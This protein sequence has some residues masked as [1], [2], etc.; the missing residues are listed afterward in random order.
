MDAPRFSIK[1]RLYEGQNSIIFRGV[2]ADGQTRVVIKV[3]K[4]EYP[5][6]RAL[7]QLRREYAT[8]REL[9]IPGVIRVF[10]LESY[11]NG[12]ALVM[13]DDGGVPLSEIIRGEA[14]Q[15]R[16]ALELAI[17]LSDTLARLHER[18]IIHKDIKPHN[19]L[20]N[21]ATGAVKLIDF[22][23]ATNLAHA[24]APVASP[25][26]IEGT[27]MYM[28]PEQ[29]GRVNRVVDQR[30][31]LYSLGVTLYEMLTGSV[32]FTAQD[33]MELVHSHIA[34]TP[35]PPWV[36]TPT[37]PRVLSDIVMKLLA[38]GP[39]DRYQHAHGLSADLARCL[40]E[41]DADGSVRP[42]ELG[43]R[44]RADV[45]RIPQKLYG[46]E[47][48]V[49]A[50]TE[51]YARVQDGR[52]ELLLVSGGAGVGKSMLAQEAHKLIA[53]SGGRVVS[54]K[55]DLVQ[56]EV[57]FS[58]LASALTDLV[59]QMLTESSRTLA[60]W[61]ARIA[62]AL[63]GCGQLVVDLVPE[64]SRVIGPQPPL[65]PLRPAESQ[66]RFGLVMQNFVRALCPRT[67][68]LI[69]LL[70]DL[71]WADA[72]TLSLLRLLLTDPDGGHLLIVGAYRDAEVDGGHPLRAA[73]SQLR[74]DGAAI[75]ELTL[76]P[77]D[78]PS[79]RALLADTLTHE[80]PGAPVQGEEAARLDALASLVF[81]KTHGNPFFL[82][83]FLTA[84]HRGGQLRFDHA[85]G[86]WT[87]DPA[88]I[89]AAPIT[90]NVAEL[91]STRLREFPEDTQQLLAIAACV[92]HEFD[93]VTLARISQRG[94]ARVAEELWP[95]LEA[96]LVVPLD[97]NFRLLAADDDGAPEVGELAVACRFLHDRV[98]QAALSL[99]TPEALHEVHLRIGRSLR[100]GHAGPLR[101]DAL[102]E[103]VRHLNAGAP[104]L[105]DPGE[106]LG[107]ARANLEAARAA[108]RATAYAAG[109]A[110]AAAGIAVLPPDAWEVEF[111]LSLGLHRER[112]E[113][114]YMSGRIDEADASLVELIGRARSPL[115]QADLYALRIML[116]S[117][118]GRFA[119]GLA[120]SREGLA[121]FGERLPETRDE[122]AAEFAAVYA[123]IERS[124][125]GR[126][127]EA[128]ID[129]PVMDDPAHHARLRLLNEAFGPCFVVDA[130]L[131]SVV[132]LKHV[133]LSLTH[134]H[135]ELSAFGYASYGY[136]LVGPL[137]RPVDALPFGALALRLLERFTSTEV[138]SRV[139]FMVGFY[140]GHTRP[141]GDSLP[142]FERARQLGLE[143]GDFMYASQGAVFHALTDL[144]RGEDLTTLR[145]DID[146]GLA[147]MVRTRDAM[148]TAQLALLGHVV[149]AL[150][151]GQ[152]FEGPLVGDNPGEAAWLAG[153]DASG[154]AIVRFLHHVTKLMAATLFEHYDEALALLAAAEPLLP[155]AVGGPYTADLPFYAGLALAGRHGQASDPEERAGLLARLLEQ[156]AE[157]AK[158]A[159]LCPENEQHRL[160]ILD[161]EIARIRGAD[162]VALDEYDR[163][164]EWARRGQF[165]H[166]EAIAN[167][168]CAR[169]HQQRGRGQ[170]ARVYLGQARYGYERWGAL[171]KVRALEL[172]Y[173]HLATRAEMSGAPA[174]SSSSRASISSS[175]STT[176]N[177][178][179][180]LSSVIKAAHALTAE[181]AF[182]PLLEKII[183]IMIENAGARRGVLLLE[184]EGRLCVVA[185][186]SVDTGAY[187]LKQPYLPAEAAAVPMSIINYVAHTSDSVILD[188][189]AR[190][191]PFTGDPYV[192]RTS[193]R[194]V[195]C[196]PL[197]H[198]TKLTG[199]LYLEN[200]LLPAV[201]PE[202]R[203][204]TLKL[205]ASQ[206]AISIENANLYAN[207]ERL[208]RKRTEEL[209]RA[210]ESLTAS[211]AELDAF[212]R[213]VA[214]DLKNPLGAMVGYSEYLLENLPDVDMDEIVGVV[215][216]LR[217]ASHTATNIIDELLL[218]SGVRKQQ[219]QRA[220]L[221]MA[222]I[223][224]Q[225]EQ[226]MLYMLREY[227]GEL[228]VPERWPA[229]LGYAPWIEEAWTNYISNG[230][231]YAGPRLVLGADEPVDGQVRFWVRDSG[232][233]IDE[234][235]QGKLFA[236]FSRLETVRAEGHGLGLSIVRRII[237][238]LGGRVGVE[239]K[240][241]AGSLFYFTLPAAPPA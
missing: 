229:A 177:H 139:H 126:G 29:S 210:N 20:V 97:S 114:D 124:L 32:P 227:G 232:P 132:I 50:L 24:A 81:E 30:S 169:F 104:R 52:P 166:H 115:D 110:F 122:I 178:G 113:C 96:G 100:D 92:G 195:L 133:L 176:G 41:L 159:A 44:D 12:L 59:R 216:N 168:L 22:G 203:L 165:V 222:A 134:G 150:Q 36:R 220:P 175:L 233:G 8:L 54:G 10:S 98:Q 129:A 90:E 167:E 16:R 180:D 144:R 43:L 118:Q 106:R 136:L 194:S 99:S 93:V 152:W 19:I 109:A 53:R 88:A 155:L 85:G 208:V 66:N 219:V 42:F 234:E 182:E 94:L 131:G 83:Q 212:A 137:G 192:A 87:W 173:P 157:T 215:E 116:L 223:I 188:D 147:L 40:A 171:A 105:T 174:A 31:D 33:A 184:R 37:V 95:A 3:L 153:V 151:Q 181:I 191:G 197:V 123:A 58:A 238:R 91:M 64:L 120:A 239:S 190:A 183:A 172:A 71:Q 4:G 117:S 84:L 185:E 138:A 160:H 199:V 140:T 46:R 237:E 225:V 57:P 224:A 205:I 193:M 65:P 68:P 161:A 189:A 56:R 72:G 211:N 163:A 1:Q 209:H 149:D 2:L 18:G 241:G 75:T 101:G 145:E 107:L 127:V 158:W 5:S 228:V 47:A 213:T 63:G 15:P 103:V 14:L 236:E 217:R 86:A 35:V 187:T 49:R 111:A 179:L 7:R 45:L 55:F 60:E 67:S 119:E 221:D 79:V 70:D 146:A 142:H 196:T 9:D 80:R 170:I 121:R 148:S 207:M 27:L 28:S 17:A 89:A 76:G 21:S 38:K 202:G 235:A 128:L 143:T 226:R 206:A 23:I 82:G 69:V 231:K 26:A 48:E 51:A 61:Q 154:L 200:E 62:L 230:L 141:L 74:K 135:G 164:I 25:E 218:L 78:L 102:F 214:H 156:R 125:A 6:P 204:H 130:R 39:E 112:A 240:V 73:V 34:R 201:F 108:K 77:L 11:G 198:Q 186:S 13:E 162:L